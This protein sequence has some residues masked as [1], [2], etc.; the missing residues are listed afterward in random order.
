[1]KI[2]SICYELG[3]KVILKL[4]HYIVTDGGRLSR[5]VL[6]NNDYYSYSILKRPLVFL[7]F[8]KSSEDYETEEYFHE[9]SAILSHLYHKGTRIIINKVIQD[10]LDYLGSETVEVGFVIAKN[11]NDAQ[12]S[13]IEYYN[14]KGKFFKNSNY[15]AAYI[16]PDALYSEIHGDDNSQIWKEITEQMIRDGEIPDPDKE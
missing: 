1:M 16:D 12:K 8:S 14:I 6:I 7:D 11:L 10:E 4:Y 2:T 13:L 15:Y 5:K 3:D 9:Y